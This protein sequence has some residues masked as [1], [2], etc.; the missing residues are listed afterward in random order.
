MTEDDKRKLYYAEV[1]LKS[2]SGKDPTWL[3]LEPCMWPMLKEALSDYIS[4]MKE[5][6]NENNS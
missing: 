2:V 3:A 5:K 6:E 4:K 1:L